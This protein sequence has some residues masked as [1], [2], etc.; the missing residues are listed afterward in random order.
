M[1]G[2]ERKKRGCD[3]GHGWEE[4]GAEF[5]QE[6]YPV[7]MEADLQQALQK[8]PSHI[9]TLLPSKKSRVATAKRIRN[10]T[11]TTL[12]RRTSTRSRGTT[13]SRRMST[14]VHDVAVSM[15]PDLS[16]NLS[17]E[18]RTWEEIMQIKAMPVCM[19]QKIQLKNQLQSATKLRL[20]GFEQLKW[21]RRKAWQQ[22]RIRMKEAYTKMGL[23][24]TSLK[25]IGGHFGMGVVA[26]F[27]FIK[28]LL[29]LNLLLFAIIFLL[30]VL[31]A[32]VLEVP[33][34]EI[35]SFNDT[36]SVTCCSELYRNK[37]DERNISKI[38]QDRFDYT[39]IFYG[40]YTHK[41]YESLSANFYYNSPLSYI[42]AIICVFIVSL[43]AIVRSAAK[44]FRERVVEGE[45]QFYRYCNLIFG[46]WDY[47]I[48]NKRSASIK[49]KALY[50]E[51]KAFLES[52]RL[53]EERRNR[54][55]EEET[56][57]FFIRLFVNL[58]ILTVLGG[59]GLFVYYII[60]FSFAQLSAHDY[61]IFYEFLPYICIIVLNVAVPFLFRYLIALEHY[62]PS[63]VVE[64]TLY[65]TM[66]FRF[67]SL[68]VLLTSL[69]NLVADKIPANEC[70]NTKNNQP[71]C[72]ESFV[73]QQLF[74]LYHTD[75]LMQFFMAFFINFPRSLI[76]RHTQNKVL[77]FV[78]EQEFDL[79][80]HALDIFYSQT[81]CWLGCFFAPLLF[82]FA[83]F[84]TFILF[85]IKKFACLMNSTPSNKI[86]RASRS[87]C[88]FMFNLLICFI[89]AMIPVGY[90]IAEIMPSKSCGP[91][92]GLESVW[93]LLTMTF[94]Q[95]PNWLQSALSFLC[96]AGFGIPAF[97]IL[98]LL[99]YYYYVMWLANKHMVTVLKNQLVLEGHDKQFLL[100]RLSAFIK[101]QQDQNKF[102]QEQTNELNTFQHV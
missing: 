14:N 10:D 60:D 95:F 49:H 17:N 37:T 96:T 45:G 39:M 19:S 53:E 89:L 13:T 44:G 24:N 9:A 81:I 18:E 70:T 23:W 58:I 65:R 42:C 69:Y 11:K 92:R 82:M 80:K 36:V 100:N 35:C 77:R 72:W 52:E 41:I 26:Y 64:V 31:P 12:R 75:M 28:W 55:P 101:Q 15:L 7:A 27:L 94:S 22:F 30:I 62:N 99:L 85:Y 48:N 46:G 71:L 5:Y 2:G 56:K 73:G 66:F 32:I 29:Y 88:L 97:V 61:D 38:M 8:D 34:N 16:E 6:S 57:L 68:A 1:S 98:S 79:P 83:V 3:R 54:T 93:S 47:C 78:G 84:G 102:H 76:A 43:V 33:Q 51:M 67:A 63:Y 86:Y 74:K 21:Q 25:N 91:F 90:S 87:Y 59:C 50:N 40:S 4:A 20:Q